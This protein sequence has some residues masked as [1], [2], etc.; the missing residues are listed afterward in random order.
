MNKTTSTKTKTE[1]KVIELTEEELIAK[2][3]EILP[4]MH[5]WEKQP[6][7]IENV[8]ISKFPEKG[9][10]VERGMLTLDIPDMAKD[11]HVSSSERL[12]QLITIFGSKKNQTTLRKIAGVLDKTVAKTKNL[13]APLREEHVLF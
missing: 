6:T 4:Q 1:E 7:S 13:P 9:S 11:I 3:L 8:Y 12:E 5:A 10:R 2:F